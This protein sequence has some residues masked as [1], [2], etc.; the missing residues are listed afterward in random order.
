MLEFIFND[1]DPTFSMIC[2]AF[3]VVPIVILKLSLGLR[4]RISMDPHLF[5]F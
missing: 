3:R 5:E 2:F 1:L 4:I